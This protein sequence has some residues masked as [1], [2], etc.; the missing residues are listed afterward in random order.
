MGSKAFHF[1]IDVSAPDGTPVYA[2][3]G[4][5]VHAEGA[6]NVGVVTGDGDS[7]GYWHI[8]PRVRHGQKVRKHALLGHIAKGWGHVHFADRVAGRYRNPLRAGALTPFHDYGAPVVDRI[9][10][11]RGAGTSTRAPSPASST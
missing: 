7:H 1:G 3:A 9:V 6:Q 10:T 11:E 2:V 4:G 5:T 8:V